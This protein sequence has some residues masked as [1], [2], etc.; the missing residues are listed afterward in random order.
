MTHTTT[1]IM[2]ALDGD[3]AYVESHILAF[4]RLKKDGEKFDTLTLARAV[5]HFKSATGP[6]A[7]RAAHGLGM[8]PRDAHG[9]DL[10]PRD[11]RPGRHGSGAGSQDPDDLIYG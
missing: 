10:G 8:E 2:I 9:R 3:N 1:N 7:C 5:D 4:A 6:G 11:H